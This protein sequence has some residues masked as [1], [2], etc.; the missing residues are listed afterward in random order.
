M[1]E[2]LIFALMTLN[3]KKKTFDVARGK[4]EIGK[5]CALAKNPITAHSD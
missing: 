2:I 3:K 4:I 5:K 1:K